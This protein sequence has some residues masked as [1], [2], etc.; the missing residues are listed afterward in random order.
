M[1]SRAFRN[2]FTA[3]VSAVE[4]RFALET[5][6]KA[7]NPTWPCSSRSRFS[8]FVV[9]NWLRPVAPHQGIKECESALW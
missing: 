9:L 5:V 4:R 1:V 3:M 2:S 6:P 8:M 7:P